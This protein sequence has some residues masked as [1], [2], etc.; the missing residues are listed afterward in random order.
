MTE[1]QIAKIKESAAT[2]GMVLILNDGTKL[3]CESKEHD[4]G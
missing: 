4:I 3:Y 1:E 2:D